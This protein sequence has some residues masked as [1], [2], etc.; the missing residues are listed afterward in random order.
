MARKEEILLATLDLASERGL[1]AVT[2]SQI[3]ERVGIRK[4]DKVAL[5]G[6]NSAHWGVAYLATLAYG[7][8]SI[9]I[10]FTD[11]F[12]SAEFSVLNASASPKTGD[13]N[14]LALWAGVLLLSGA[15]VVAL[16]PRKRKQ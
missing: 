16:I 13:S 1:K 8:H 5:C 4:G 6:R 2:L 11:G 9:D 14:N 15:A 12:A 3:A 7:K 10:V